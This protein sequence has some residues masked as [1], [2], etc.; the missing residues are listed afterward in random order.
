MVPWLFA[1]VIDGFSPNGLYVALF[2]VIL[3]FLDK[4]VRLLNRISKEF[5]ASLTILFKPPAQKLI[6]GEREQ[7]GKKKVNFSMDKIIGIAQLSPIKIILL[8]GL[9]SILAFLL[10]RRIAEGMLTL[11]AAKL[12]AFIL[13]RLVIVP[14][15]IMWLIIR[16]RVFRRISGVDKVTKSRC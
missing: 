4:P 12:G 3:V 10:Y 2:S 5:I 6:R 9:W 11:E 1:D 15:L 16:N 8:S 14:F 7:T 13:L